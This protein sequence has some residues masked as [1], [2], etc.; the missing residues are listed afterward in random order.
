A[1][2]GIPPD[3]W[4]YEPNTR[5][6]LTLLASTTGLLGGAGGRGALLAGAVLLPDRTLSPTYFKGLKLK[7]GYLHRTGYRLPT[8]AERELACRAGPTTSYSYG[9]SVELVGKYGR[10]L[11]NADRHAW[12]VGGLKPNDLGLFDMHGNVF[13][14]C[15]DRYAPYAKPTAGK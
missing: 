4:C 8:E 14:W 3:Q 11:L 12:P 1:Q 13:T 10:Y 7:A 2:E 15:L 6:P 5:G 9:E